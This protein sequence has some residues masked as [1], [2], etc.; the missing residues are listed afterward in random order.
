MIY[1]LLMI[2]IFL[3]YIIYYQVYY[4]TFSFNRINLITTEI[5]LV[6]IW[7]LTRFFKI[8]PSTSVKSRSQQY[9]NNW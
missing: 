9:L 7:T 4:I 1:S 5:Y 2:L 6:E 3:L 8:F